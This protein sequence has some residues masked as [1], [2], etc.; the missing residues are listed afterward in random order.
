[1]RA[2]LARFC[3][4]SAERLDLLTRVHQQAIELNL[5][6]EQVL[7]V[8]EADRA[9]DRSAVSRVEAQGLMLVTPFWSDKVERSGDNLTSSPTNL[10]YVCHF[11]SCHLDR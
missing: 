8:I 5:P 2:W 7:S 9:V 11:L 3:A 4:D 6:P 1:M 10:R